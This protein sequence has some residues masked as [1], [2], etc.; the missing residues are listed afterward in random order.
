M[1]RLSR[2]LRIPAIALALGATSGP[3]IHANAVCAFQQSQSPKQPN[4]DRP[5]QVRTFMGTIAKS[6]SQFV[7]RESPSEKW[8]QLDDQETAAKFDGKAVKVS[9]TLDGVGN[10]IHIRSI[11][12]AGT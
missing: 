11:E 5:T 7:L 9:G 4:P 1:V 8:Y 12:E 10:I 6:G 2:I 3:A